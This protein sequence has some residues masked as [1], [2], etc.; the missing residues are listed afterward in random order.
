MDRDI[1][2]Y[3]IV[4]DLEE[5]GATVLIEPFGRLIDMEIGA[6]I[7]AA[8]D[9]PSHQPRRV[10]EAGNVNHDGHV[11]VVDTIVV[12]WWFE[13]MGIF[14]EPAF[15]VINLGSLAIL[16]VIYDEPLG[17]IKRTGKHFDPFGR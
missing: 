16:I 2:M 11:V 15:K 17:Q 3:S 5:H 7:G 10:L 12:D 4:D 6:G 8:N 14:L 1:P 9:L 13:K